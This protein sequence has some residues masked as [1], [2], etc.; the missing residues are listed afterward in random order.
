MGDEILHFLLE[1]FIGFNQPC[2]ATFMT[3]E[4]LLELM[5]LFTTYSNANLSGN[6]DNS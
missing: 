2:M 6:P 1:F 5:D 4:A 3:I